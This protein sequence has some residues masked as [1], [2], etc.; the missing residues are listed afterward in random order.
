MHNNLLLRVSAFQIEWHWFFIKRYRNRLNRM[1][2]SGVPLTSEKLI[3]LARRI[4]N[5]CILVK[6]S[7]AMYI[8]IA[9]VETK[10]LAIE[11]DLQKAS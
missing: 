10:L 8:S 3:R 6:Y 9:E 7:E 11:K 1:A 2:A 4:A 5:H